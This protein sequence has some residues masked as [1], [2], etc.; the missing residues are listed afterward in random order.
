MALAT[1]M[2]VHTH[3][4]AHTLH[5]RSEQSNL[6]LYLRIPLLT[7]SFQF[8]SPSEATFRNQFLKLTSKN[9]PKMS[10]SRI[11]NVHYNLEGLESI[12]QWL[13]VRIVVIF[14]PHPITRNDQSSHKD[15]PSQS[16]ELINPVTSIDQTSHNFLSFHLLPKWLQ[17]HLQTPF[18]DSSPAPNPITAHI[19]RFSCHNT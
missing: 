15:W 10:F 12:W 19:T 5:S 7:S 11:F 9:D 4:H 17:P 16:Q 2:H 13:S 3:T 1:F 8:S 18:S 6:S 14:L